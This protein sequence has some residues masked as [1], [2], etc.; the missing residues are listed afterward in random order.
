ML[1][2]VILCGCNSK[3][4][5]AG[6]SLSQTDIFFDTYVTITIYGLDDTTS[7]AIID[8]CMSKCAYYENLFS[9]NIPSS[10]ISRINNR[11]QAVVEVSPETIVLLDKALQ[12]SRQSD[13]LFDV[14]IYS[15]S[16]LWDFSSGSNQIPSSTDLSEAVKHIDYKKI[17]IDSVNNT[18]SLSDDKIQIDIGGIAKGYIADCLCEYIKTTP[19]SGAIINLGGDLMLYG[20]KGN[21]SAYNI[22]ITNPF[23]QSTPIASA[24]LTDKAIATSGTYIRT[25]SDGTNTYHHILDPKNGYSVDTDL[26]SATIITKHSIDADTLCTIAILLGSQKALSYIEALP[27]TE[28]LLIKEDGTMLKTSSASKYFTE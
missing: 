13:G 8:E 27:D 22:G 17:S 9:A 6:K 1:S 12:Y 3:S 16:K 2:L 21:A 23:G 7:E 11:I 24:C 18:V 20:N 25:V 19:A 10:D 5:T 28:A 4:T 26:I 14:S 15:A